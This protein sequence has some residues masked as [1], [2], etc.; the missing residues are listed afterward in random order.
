M[1][2]TP[3]PDWPYAPPVRIERPPVIQRAQGLPFDQLAWPDFERLVL[4]VVAADREVLDCRVYGVPGQAQH[5]IDLLAAPVAAPGEQA[6]FQCKNVDVFRA[7]DVQAAV[8]KFE[9]GPWATQ[10]REFTLCV[11]SALES[12]ELADTIIKE[13][14]RLA[15]RNITFRVW[16]GSSSG[17]LNV[18]LKD[19]PQIV[20]DF[21]GREWV[22]VFNGQAVAD[23]LGERL[24]GIDFAALRERLSELYR[25][26]FSQHDPGL[27]P[28][29]SQASDYLQRY[30]PADIVEN[31]VVEQGSLTGPGRRED[32]EGT[33]TPA[34]SRLEHGPQA[35]SASA[36]S[37]YSVRRPTWEWLR[38]KESCVVL[39]EPGHGKSALLRQLALVLNTKDFAAEMPLGTAH[40]RRLP[41]WI[42]FARFAAA[43]AKDS[44][45]SVED[46]FC[47][48]LHQ[49]GYGDTQPLFR[50]ALRNSEFVLL[51]DG[52]DE[53]AEASEG[54][55]ALDRVVTFGRSHRAIVIC[56]SRPRSFASLPVPTSWPAAMLAPL[57]DGQIEQLARR[58]FAIVE[59]VSNDESD[60]ARWARAKPRGEGF[61]TA[62]KA[63]ARTQELARNPLL[64]QALIELYRLSHRLPEARIR[65]YGEII[66]LFLR[67]HPQAR[68]HAGFAEPP[69]ALEGLREADLHDI[70]V[71]IA[72]DTQSL[73]ENDVSSSVR[74]ISRTT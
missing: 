56:T 48:W 22:R 57:D 19:L 24:D 15:A 14:V 39:G 64:C 74:S 63:S 8:K 1:T 55:E 3:V 12:T 21:F 66:D 50:R 28:W 2:G 16:D 35:T 72:F 34:A 30:V 52:L 29:Q 23:D 53:G 5:G 31:A 69:A 71:R 43:I 4:R 65:A 59:S 37:T 47:S 38:D 26:I 33:A 49:Y 9:D 40:L 73:C 62:I 60:E 7:A 41:V 67:R 46:F 17:Q 10:T 68:A 25:V 32:A 44:S 51:V 18:R 54:R 70:L 27:R 11:A 13:R 58:W 6:C 36:V 20:D 42:S 61:C 45:I